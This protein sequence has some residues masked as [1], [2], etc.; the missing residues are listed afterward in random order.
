MGVRDQGREV[1]KKLVKK[2]DENRAEYTRSA[3]SYNETQLRVDFLNPFLEALGWDVDN[4]KGV[5]QH[6]R[7]VVHE[8]IVL[9][10]DDERS[11][12][13]KPDYAF[14]LGVE[15]KFFLEAKKPSVAIATND[16]SAFQVRR[17]GWN[18]QMPISVLTNF[19]KLAIYDCSNRP[20]SADN[21]S[22]AR[23]KIYNYTE[24]VEKFDDIYDQI[25][26]EVVYSGAFDTIFYVD[27]SRTGTEPFDEFFLNQIERWRRS[28]AEDLIIN[29]T[30]L[31]QDELN[32][33]LQRLL[34]RIIFLRVCE[35][36]DLEK[37]ESLKSVQ[38]YQDLK[39]LYMSADQ[40]YNA[41]L[42][43]F[44]EDELSLDIEISSGVLIQVFRELYFPESP[45][46]FAVVEADVIS[47]IYERTNQDC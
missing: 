38:S 7:E 30:T 28:F 45:Y 6:L 25:S 27:R 12:S 41:G 36:R 9:I 32:F 33:L 8:D 11:A 42:F 44:I 14:R 1:V 19:D 5:P 46:A 2:F 23:I 20:L 22:V 21:A 29:N 39:K 35:D 4:E 37:Y 43:N 31:N 16:R 40:R 15:R 47:E 3:S 24:Y 18:A 10:D 13:K 17:Y 34:N 26:R